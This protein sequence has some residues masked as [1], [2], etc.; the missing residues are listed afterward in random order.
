MLSKEKLLGKIKR[1]LSLARHNSEPHEAALALQKAH[2]LMNAHGFSEKDVSLSQVKESAARTGNNNV[3]PNLWSA[4][5]A[6]VVAK[7]FGC[8]CFYVSGNRFRHP[9][10]NFVGLEHKAEIS[11]YCFEVL[12]RF[13]KKARSEYY[14][15]LRGKRSSRIKKA[16]AFAIGWVIAVR[17]KV[18]AFATAT[19]DIVKEYILSKWRGLTEIELKNPKGRAIDSAK[20]EGFIEGDKVE[21]HNAVGAKFQKK[22]N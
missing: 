8:D 6:E 16:N 21:L 18:D 17:L 9:F 19:P 22:I 1:L 5:L 4:N 15:K 3:A 13:C 7:A 2:E 14:Q 10:F 12:F 11:A 20:T